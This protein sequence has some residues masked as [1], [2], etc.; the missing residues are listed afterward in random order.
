MSG[1]EICEE[2]NWP[3]FQPAA[4]RQIYWRQKQESS[5]QI[6]I[7]KEIRTLMAPIKCLPSTDG[8]SRG[9]WLT[10]Q[11]EHINFRH[12]Y[13]SCRNSSALVE[14]LCI[15]TLAGWFG[16]KLFSTVNTDL[17]VVIGSV[18][19]FHYFLNNRQTNRWRKKQFV[20]I[21]DNII[22]CPLPIAFTVITMYI[23][24]SFERL[25]IQF[26]R[27]RKFFRQNNIFVINR[28]AARL[29]KAGW[30]LEVF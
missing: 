10:D 5:N 28:V 3:P 24:L 25:F 20:K 26:N 9:I 21:T 30:K 27:Q 6:V 2:L 18:F 29:A 12:L 7:K 17:F 16:A 11:L 19:T 14:F 23:Y 15:L 4:S 13:F 22:N 8:I 1:N